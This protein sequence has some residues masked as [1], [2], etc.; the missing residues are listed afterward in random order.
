MK[1]LLS[2]ALAISFLTL[3]FTISTQAAPKKVLLYGPTL[4]ANGEINFINNHSTEFQGIVPPPSM[5]G[6]RVFS[7]QE[8]VNATVAD[9]QQFDAIIISDLGTHNPTVPQAVAIASRAMWGSAVNGN[10]LVVAGDPRADLFPFG[11]DIPAITAQGIR[12]AADQP[13]EAHSQTG[14]YIAIDHLSVGEDLGV[15][16]NPTEIPILSWLGSFRAIEIRGKDEQVRMVL[17]HP[18]LDVV[19]RDVG[20][21]FIQST[22]DQGHPGDDTQGFHS[23]PAGF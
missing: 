4:R 19:G 9:F 1:T 23:W 16:Q 12:F 10:I 7:E 17:E 20:G 3:A 6:S 13:G 5:D 2:C 15:V 21:Y 8:W 14:L 11:D 22:D 18:I